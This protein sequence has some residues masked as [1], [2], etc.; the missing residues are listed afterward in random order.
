MKTFY[1]KMDVLQLVNEES[2]LWLNN[3]IKN[4]NGN[5]NNKIWL[6]TKDCDI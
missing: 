1:E 6:M 3:F 4:L 5:V 2:F